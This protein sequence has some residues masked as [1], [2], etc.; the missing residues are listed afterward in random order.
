MNRD[1]II[2]IKAIMII[3]SNWLMLSLATVFDL[4]KMEKVVK[5]IIKQ[6]NTNIDYLESMVRGEKNE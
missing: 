4:L 6:A 1:I 2:R 3:L 5:K